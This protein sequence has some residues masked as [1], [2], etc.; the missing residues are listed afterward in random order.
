MTEDSEEVGYPEWRPDI[1]PWSAQARERLLSYSDGVWHL[2]AVAH[3]SKQRILYLRVRELE[4]RLYS[5]S[6]VKRL[7]RWQ[8]PP[9]EKTHR[10]EWRMR[11]A[12]LSLLEGY[13][14]KMGRV[15]RILDLGCGNGWLSRR[16]AEIEG[17][18]CVGLDT[19][20][21]EL[22]QGARVFAQN[23]SLCFA[24][25]DVFL[26]PEGLEDSGHGWD[27][28]TLVSSVQYFPNLIAL[29]ERL[30]SLLNPKGEIHIWDSN[31]YEDDEVV[32]AQARTEIYYRRLGIPEMGS[33]YFHHTFGEL[34][35]W[36]DATPN[37]DLTV[38][39]PFSSYRRPRLVFPW[40]R[41]RRKS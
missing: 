29:M 5:D 9:G 14:R 19:N 4:A 17:C 38:S 34:R 28:I 12:T 7:P 18:T 8:G 6:V 36:V 20:E 39:H 10:N 24:L 37:L 16:L 41:L 26:F 23:P 31:F 15:L 40:L 25:G 3:L 1:L 27:I 22:K 35:S 2:S 30:L 11:E 32:A 33:Y 13:L 21:Q